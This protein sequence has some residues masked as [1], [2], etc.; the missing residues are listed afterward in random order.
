MAVWRNRSTTSVPAS[1]SISYLIGS[2]PTGTSMMTLTS[3]GGSIPIEMAS[4]RMDGSAWLSAQL[5]DRGLRRGV[6][7]GCDAT[8]GQFER[9]SI[10]PGEGDLVERLGPEFF[11]TAG[12]HAAAQRPV[13]LGRRIVVRQRPDHHALQAALQQGT[14]CGGEQPAAEAEALKF[15]AQIEFVDLAFEVQ[16]ARAVAA[17]IG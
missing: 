12:D 4:M 3:R 14:P 10:G 15:R 6:K 16:A 9:T 1:L 11:G 7:A 8:P 17:V 2:P 5:M 13:K